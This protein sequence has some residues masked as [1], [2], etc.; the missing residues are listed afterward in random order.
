MGHVANG[1]GVL[2]LNVGE[3]GTLVIDPEVEDAVLVG[4]H[5]G[6]CVCRGILGRAGL[7][8]GKGK[9][10][11]GGKHAELELEHIVGGDVEGGP[12]VVGVLGEGDG[13]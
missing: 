4:Q 5:K 12:G 8:K 9:A 3:E 13:V 7:V 6:G 1:D 11:E 10:V 2:L